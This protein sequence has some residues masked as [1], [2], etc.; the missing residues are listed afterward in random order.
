M[1]VGGGWRVESSGR[2]DRGGWEQGRGQRGG[3]QWRVGGG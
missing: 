1:A 3:K 2:T